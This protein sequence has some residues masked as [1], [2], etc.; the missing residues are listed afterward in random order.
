[1]LIT[2]HM[3]IEVDIF[4]AAVTA[5][6]D[7][8]FGDLTNVGSSNLRASTGLNDRQELDLQA[9][10][11]APA[12]PSCLTPFSSTVHQQHP[13]LPGPPKRAHAMEALSRSTQDTSPA[14]A[15][16]LA[17]RSSH[18]LICRALKRRPPVTGVGALSLR[19][20]VP[21]CNFSDSIMKRLPCGFGWNLIRLAWSRANCWI[22]RSSNRRRSCRRKVA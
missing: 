7:K 9:A 12:L 8:A 21:A 20:M 2:Q 17:L 4:Y 14:S 11:P 5:A 15:P 10:T 19:G 13:A 18:R 6:V 22:A 16:A 1:M 3:P